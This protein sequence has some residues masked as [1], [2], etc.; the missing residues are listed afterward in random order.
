MYTARELQ[1]AQGFSLTI[2]QT[3]YII[4]KESYY[5]EQQYQL[6]LSIGVNVYRLTSKDDNQLKTPLEATRT[7]YRML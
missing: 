3:N 2:K 1:W 6:K 7:V 4:Y 5:Y